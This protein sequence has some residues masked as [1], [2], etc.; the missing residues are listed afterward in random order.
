M[1]DPRPQIRHL[2][3]PMAK[4]LLVKDIYHV[5]AQFAPPTL[6]EEWDN[7]GLQV[8][9][10][11]DKVRGILVSLDVTENA[12]WEAVEEELNLV[13]THHP[14]FLRPFR[15]LDETT[16]STRLARLATQLGI[17]IL[18]F[19]TNLDST[20]EGLND[21]LAKKLGIRRLKPLIPSRDPKLKTSGLGRVGAIRKTT[22][23]NLVREVSKKLRLKNLRYVGDPRHPIS[24]AAV[25]TGSGGG[26]FLD[27][28]KAGAD[29]LITGDI[30]YHY[31]LDALAE[32]IGLIDIGHYA[33]EIGMVPLIAQKLR[34]WTKNRSAKIK[35]YETQVCYDPFNF[36]NA[37]L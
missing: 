4:P 1:V 24:K 5:L 12:L 32:G 22:L 19:H 26:F 25:M 18:S 9:T 20:R 8:G 37:N 28:K 31:A 27:A 15:C 23:G 16:I 14:L 3:G 35:V 36:W 29:V 21:L 6:A 2:V 33:G 13:V 34:R 17:N 7:V 11:Q 10:F 30:K